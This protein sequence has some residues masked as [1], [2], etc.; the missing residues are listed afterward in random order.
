MPASP[1]LAAVM[2]STIPPSSKQI[3]V[4]ALKT[5]L[6]HLLAIRPVSER[7]ICS[8]LHCTTVDIK[9]LLEKYGNKSRLDN[10]KFE[11]SDKGYKLLDVW[12]FPYKTQEDREA[13]IERAIKSYDRQRISVKDDVWERLLPIEQRGQ[14]KILS[15]LSLHEGPIQRVRTPRIN[16]QGAEEAKSGGEASG[17]DSDNRKDRLAPGNAQPIARSRSQDPIKKQRVSEKEAQ[18]RRLLS[19]NPKKLTQATTAK[20]SKPATKK[21]AKVTTS[22]AT[23]VKS[24]EFVRDSDE[25]VEMEDVI[26]VE[27][28][29]ATSKVEV[30]ATKAKMLGTRRPDTDKAVVQKVSP[31]ASV[32]DHE[33]KPNL[34]STSSTGSAQKFSDASQN[35]TAMR[36][37]LSHKR[38]TS[39]PMK[40]SPLGSSPP[41]NASDFDNE[42]SII[43][44]SSSSAASPTVNVGCENGT[45][46]IGWPVR[47]LNKPIPAELERGRSD[48]GPK[49]KANDLDSHIHNHRN[50]A[51]SNNFEPP[52]KRHQALPESPPT[53]DSSN[54]ATPGV[55]KKILDL[56]T[57]FKDFHRA[58]TKAHHEIADLPRPPQDKV[59]KLLRMHGRLE[60]MK[61]EITKAVTA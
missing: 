43:H 32:V 39:S 58:Y 2:P 18:T 51:S 28:P 53:S 56:A 42:K 44:G 25:D 19:K 59:E 10:Q 38:S 41:A 55:S 30:Q 29:K 9:E 57:K 8:S 27:A 36:R 13:A 16:V 7:F 12:K 60:E 52:A 24:A 61:A 34:S 11:L 4:E 45:P 1:S 17:T 21:E 20:D 50:V 14:G 35:S 40:P 37:T 33:R 5:A 31:S 22:N 6:V 54:E 49:R 48:H 15:N 47:P 23:K 46:T 3:K 26:T